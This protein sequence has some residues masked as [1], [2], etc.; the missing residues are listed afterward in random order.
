M[1]AQGTPTTVATTQLRQLLVEL[2][3][4]GSAAADTFE[5]LAGKSFT[6]FIAQGGNLAGALAIMEQ[7]AADSNLRLSDM[8][9]SVEAGNAA[10]ALTGAGAAKFAQELQAAADASGA[11][12]EAAAIMN[13]SLEHQEALAKAAKEDDDPHRRRAQSRPNA[14]GWSYRRPLPNGR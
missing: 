3:Q 5:K 2:S 13:D 14:R 11:T 4:D 6:E 12:E 1:T 8:F 7:G 10:L 9:G